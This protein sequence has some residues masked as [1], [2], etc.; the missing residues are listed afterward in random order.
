MLT[1][2]IINTLTVLCGALIGTFLRWLTNRFSDIFPKNGE[3]IENRLEAIIMQGVSL[4]V[5]LIG[6]SGS[7]K[8]QN[9]LITILSRSHLR[10]A[11]RKR[12]HF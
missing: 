2:T 11:I 5:L 3:D 10:T 4:C 9:T 8:G 7:L 12:L 6:I 1:G